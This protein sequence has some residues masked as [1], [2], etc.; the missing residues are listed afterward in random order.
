MGRV[1]LT[2]LLCWVTDFSWRYRDRQLI[3]HVPM[4]ED[5]VVFHPYS[6]VKCFVSTIIT[7]FK[8][9]SKLT[10]GGRVY[11]FVQGGGNTHLN[12]DLI[13][14]LYIHDDGAAVNVVSQGVFHMGGGPP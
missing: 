7:R 5:I 14:H 3:W 10:N 6:P 2:A 8:S 9:N 1:R 11:R 13:L 4:D 12:C